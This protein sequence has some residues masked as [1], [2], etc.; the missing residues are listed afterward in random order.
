MVSITLAVPEDVKER[1]D[2]FPEMNWSGFVR[3]TVEDK[4]NELTWKEEL[5]KKLGKEKA[6]E[7]WAVGLGKE[8][9]KGRFGRVLSELPVKDKKGLKR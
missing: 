3:K 7:D 8:S 9:K 5:L 1:M 6:F 2:K 4:V